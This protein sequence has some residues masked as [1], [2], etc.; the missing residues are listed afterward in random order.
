MKILITTLFISLLF[1]SNSQNYIPGNTYFG[2]DSLTEYRCG[3]LPIILSSPHGGYKTPATLPNRNCVGCVTVRDSYTQE[4]TRQIEAAILFKTGCYPHVI[5]NRL[6]RKKLDANREI[7]EATDSNSVTEPYWHDYMNFIDSARNL[8]NKSNQKG[9]FLDIHGHGHSIQR[10]ELGY[11]LSGT[12]LRKNDSSLDSSPLNTKTSLL[13][14]R[15]SNLNSYSHSQLIRGP[16]CFG[17][18]IQRRGF[19]A[20]PSD[21]I[22]FPLIGEPY[23]NGG[24]NTVRFGSKNGGTIDAIQIESH[25]GVRFNYTKRVEYADSLAEAILE[26]VTKHYFVNFPQHYCNR[27]SLEER[28]SI[29]PITVFPNP[30]TG[31]IY[32]QGVSSNSKIDLFSMEGKLISSFKQFKNI[33]LSSLKSG[34]YL[35]RVSSETKV[36]T[37]RIIKN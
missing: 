9:I 13:N 18:M 31:L 34:I 3:N 5:I 37:L 14:L 35:L 8:V 15:Y 29:E 22:P 11:L 21:S 4:L 19:P 1:L 24:Y 27:V 10:L 28:N 36:N 32:L 33:N 26:Y 25:Q 20:V 23:F 2:T 17:A 16:Y 7:I 12:D 30:T 6:D